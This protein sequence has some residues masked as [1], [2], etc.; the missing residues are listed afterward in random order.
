ME[1]EKWCPEPKFVADPAPLDAVH[2]TFGWLVSGP[3]PLS[4][5]GATF[6]GF[7]ARPVALNEVRERLLRRS[8]PQ[9][10]RDAVWAHLVARTRVDLGHDHENGPAAG[11]RA[12]AG[13]G[14]GA[15]E[16]E[17]ATWTVGCAGV[18]LPALIKTAAGLTR[19][20]SGDPRDIH[21]AVLAGFVAELGVVDLDRAQI[22]LRLRWAAYRAGLDGVREALNAP[23]PV[24]HV[25]THLGRA[26][27]AAPPHPGG[28]PDLVLARAIADGVV[29]A[30]EADLIG[31]TR[32]DRLD[33]A[34]AARLR[35]AHYEATRKARQRAERRLRVYLTAALVEDDLTTDPVAA[36]VA[37]TASDPTP[38]HPRRSRRVTAR[39]RRGRRDP[40]PQ[41]NPDG[42]NP[43]GPTGSDDSPG[44]NGPDLCVR[45][46]RCA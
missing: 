18:A 7:P 26:A 15:R 40:A 19:R 1:D 17:A 13:G 31:A 27:P 23:I 14:R 25:V 45:E 37:R 5:D 22:M 3:A 34:A 8:C 32:L 9:S 16:V 6:D 44:L 41:T 36:M 46:P 29:S 38:P 42:P 24:G 4:V 11:R 2:A 28:H 20:F 12:T 39:G 10:V 33:M 30:D 21:A 35:G 43:S